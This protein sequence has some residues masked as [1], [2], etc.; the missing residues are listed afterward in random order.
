MNSSVVSEEKRERI[1]L[2]RSVLKE[3]RYKPAENREELRA[4]Y[5]L[6]HDE[7]ARRG[8]VPDRGNKFKI[9]IYNLL[10]DT[11]T[12]IA[13]LKDKIVS[14]VTLIPDS[15]LGL[16]MDEIYRV[17]L[18][19]L[20]LQGQKI[21]EVSML[22]SNT[23]LLGEGIS[24][25]LNSRKL[26]PVF[27]LFKLLF[28]Y[29]REIVM[30]DNF[31]IAIHPKHD[32]TYRALFFEELGP[33]KSYHSVNGNPAVARHVNLHCAREK[34]KEVRGLYK[35]FIAQLTDRSVLK[36]RIHF[37]PS[38][39]YYFFEQETDVLRSASPA[40]LRYLEKCYPDYD[41]SMVLRSATSG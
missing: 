23:S 36:R 39:I 41:F 9:S 13:L 1:Y 15:P 25:M 10:P 22:A 24:L 17:E 14:T 30:L 20:R 5:T 37:T 6:V 29:A 4:A 35:L 27:G 18:D 26:I 21:A 8:Y 7:Y 34:C 38:D 16:P 11:V 2:D 40:Q 32:L 28:D 33:L 31:C 3:I 12:F 19:A